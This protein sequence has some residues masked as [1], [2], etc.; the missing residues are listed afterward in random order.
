M[1]IP[2]QPSYTINPKYGFRYS[3]SSFAPPTSPINAPDYTM[4][5][6]EY[7]EPAKPIPTTSSSA[8]MGSDGDSDNGSAQAS[9]QMSLDQA[10][11]NISNTRDSNSYNMNITGTTPGMYG[12]A[13]D[14]SMLVPGSSFMG[15][16][17]PAVPKSGF[18]SQ[19][20]YSSLTG[21]QFKDGRSYDPILG[22]ANPEYANRNSFLQG[23][24][25][26]N[27]MD[28]I[29]GEPKYDPFG[30][31]I[32]N[33]PLGAFFSD[34]DNAFN[35][36]VNNPNRTNSNQAQAYEFA[37]ENSPLG[38]DADG[39][40]QA[41]KNT[42]AKKI[43]LDMGIAESSLGANSATTDAIQGLGY[44]DTGAATQG[45]QFSSTGTFSTGNESA[46]A[47]P[48]VDSGVYSGDMTD[49]NSDDS[50]DSYSGSTSSTAT[51]G[52]GQGTGTSYADDAASS[53]SGGGGG[54]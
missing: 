27:L 16:D 29:S 9:T 45:S 44:S 31:V 48:S 33:D 52:Q 46:A 35:Y 5:V 54:K 42:I 37:L 4:Q 23:N 50:F 36:S 18:G 11:K 19:G 20:S 49:N 7:K 47:A 41:D 51:A 8:V 2:Y 13:F 40:T 1:A 14:P 10:N 12:P 34:P 25:M 24:Y 30:D 6:P 17:A 3:G 22:Y 32:N 28:N 26:N 38:K 53:N 39:M 21:G 15:I 43:G